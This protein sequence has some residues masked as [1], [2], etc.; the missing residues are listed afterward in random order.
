M[1]LLSLEHVGIILQSMLPLWYGICK[2]GLFC[3]SLWCA[4][5]HIEP[6]AAEQH[7]E[8]NSTCKHR[9]GNNSVCFIS[10]CSWTHDKFA[11][12]VDSNSW[13]L[14]FPLQ[15]FILIKTMIDWHTLK[16]CMS[17][18]SQCI[19]LLSA[20]CTTLLYLSAALKYC[21]RLCSVTWCSKAFR[22]TLWS[23]T[24]THHLKLHLI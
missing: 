14:V 21:T 20:A 5:L 12:A 1:H 22:W 18:I 3:L 7:P 2:H 11:A 19:Q 17:I 15:V 23:D 8:G 24:A 6:P 16:L 10:S 9:C 4:H 13:H